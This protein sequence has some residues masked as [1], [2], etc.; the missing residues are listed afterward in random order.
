[1][2][3]FALSLSLLSATQVSAQ[4]GEDL[5]WG[6]AADKDEVKE[7]LA[8][9]GEEDPKTIAIKIVNLCMGFLGLIAVVIILLGGFKW[10]TAGGGEDKIAE[11]KKLL[12]AGLVGLIIVISAWGIATYVITTMIT[13]TTPAA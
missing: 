11:A 1:M 13:A 12:A 9:G 8:V 4:G 6:T 2:M 10:M 5:L 7:N 3:T